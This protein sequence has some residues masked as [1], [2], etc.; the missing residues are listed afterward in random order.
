MALTTNLVN[1]RRAKAH[2]RQLNMAPVR[3]G[4]IFYVG[5]AVSIDAVEH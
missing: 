1:G 4:E 5:S 2:R 3:A